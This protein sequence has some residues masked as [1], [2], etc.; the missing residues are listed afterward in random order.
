M[1]PNPT[2]GVLIRREN[3]GRHPHMEAEMGVAGVSTG[4]GKAKIASSRQQVK[5]KEGSSA[6]V[7][8]EHGPVDALLSGFWPPEQ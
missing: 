7:H 4:R 2:A 6:R 5:G 1:G 3:R 8:R